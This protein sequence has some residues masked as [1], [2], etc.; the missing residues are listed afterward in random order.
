MEA[1]R[2]GNDHRL[3]AR[4][5]DRLAITGVAPPTAMATAELLGF[6]TIAARIAADELGSESAEVATVH[7]GDEAAAQ[8]SNVKWLH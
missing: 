2:D 7:A 6:V 5:V 4:V 8:K 3:N 1:R